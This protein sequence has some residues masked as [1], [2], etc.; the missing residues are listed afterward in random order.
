MKLEIV[1][2]VNT[3]GTNLTEDDVLRHFAETYG[4]S[5]CR[6]PILVNDKDVFPQFTVFHNGVQI[7]A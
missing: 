4:N 2:V 1:I 3:E 6:M 5:N 7:V